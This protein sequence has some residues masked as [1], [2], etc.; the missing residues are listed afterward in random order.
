[1]AGAAISGT[2]GGFVTGVVAGGNLGTGVVVAVYGG[3]INAILSQDG[4]SPGVSGYLG[5]L[6]ATLESEG[7]L[8]TRSALGVAA[9]TAVSQA[10]GDLAA[11][12]IVAAGI[13]GYL[14]GGPRIGAA[15]VA[16]ATATILVE[17][18]IYGTSPP[19]QIA[20]QTGGGK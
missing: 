2:I 14:A 8:T 5:L 10:G 12:S 15:G 18:L 17:Y 3:I 7:I 20:A 13:G 11:R 16:G 9:A 19:A 4:V 1:M 6:G